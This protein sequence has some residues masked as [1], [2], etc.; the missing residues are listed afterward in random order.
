MRRES[1]DKA[2]DIGNSLVFYIL[3]WSSLISGKCIDKGSRLN[4]PFCLDLAMILLL[5]KKLNKNV[6]I[7]D[8][9]SMRFILKQILI[10]STD[11]EVTFTS[12]DQILI[13][14]KL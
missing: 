14:V 5:K 13:T 8:Y 3:V 11:G 6:R 2:G 4:C 7:L 9:L 10:C 12:L 1:L